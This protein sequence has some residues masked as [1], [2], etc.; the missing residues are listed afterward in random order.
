[1]LQCNYYALNIHYIVLLFA[2]YAHPLFRYLGFTISA[3]RMKGGFLA[4][5][6]FKG[7][8]TTKS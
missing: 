7:T 5:S 6:V 8:T 2:Q 4:T 1:M 3:E